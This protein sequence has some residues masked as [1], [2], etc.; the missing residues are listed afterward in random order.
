[1]ALAVGF[2]FLAAFGLSSGTILIR[3][4]TQRISPP[5]ATFLAV[6]VGTV[7]AVILA[8][9]LSRSEMWGLPLKA[10]GW[11]AALAAMGYLLARLLNYSAISM[12]GAARV[13]PMGSVAP[14]FAV[15]LAV[16]ILGERPNLLVGLGTPVIVSGLA[17]AVTGGT[18]ASHS[19]RLDSGSRLGYLLA[20]ASSSTFGGRDV[21]S[22]H[23]VT[24]VAS[25]LVTSAFALAIGSAMLL[26]LTHR[27]LL[28]G[29]RRVPV[30]YIGICA[31]AGLS[32]GLASICIFQALSR[33]PVT[34][35]S[36]IYACTP[37]FTLVMAHFL[38]QRLEAVTLLL[39]VGTLLS[40]GGVVMVILGAAG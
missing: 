40:V 5:T 22:R 30:G 36:P 34:V 33:A 25:P 21:V 39:V 24:D 27:D 12:I 3:L 35:V 1:M 23:V 17:L 2:A 11:F 14:M 31:L 8:L 29:L 20:F 18:P 16:A 28:R 26:I 32:Q 38:L 7:V 9:A 19:G 37:L 10:F 15:I 4:G 6:S 13:A